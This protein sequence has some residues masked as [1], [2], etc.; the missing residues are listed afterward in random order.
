MSS[1][2]IINRVDEINIEGWW[3]ISLLQ[4]QDDLGRIICKVIEIK[5]YQPEIEGDKKYLFQLISK[6]YISKLK[7]RDAICITNKNIIKNWEVINYEEGNFYPE[8]EN[9]TGEISLDNRFINLVSSKLINDGKC[10]E[11]K[12]NS[13]PENKNNP[14]IKSGIDYGGFCLIERLDMINQPIEYLIVL[15]NNKSKIIK[16]INKKFARIKNNKNFNIKIL[17]DNELI[18]NNIIIK[19][20]LLYDTL[21]V[22]LPKQKFWTTHKEWISDYLNEQMNEL[23][24]VFRSFNAKSIKYTITKNTEIN[25]NFTGEIGCFGKGFKGK[26]ESDKLHNTKLEYN[27]KYDKPLQD[28]YLNKNIFDALYLTKENTR[29]T[30]F[31]KRN[32]DFFYFWKHPEWIQQLSHKT[33]GNCSEMDFSH[34]ETINNNIDKNI[35][36]TLNKLNISYDKNVSTHL[37]YEI[38]LNIQYY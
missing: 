4:D 33:I 9:V 19:N 36:S 12:H 30:V 15:K 5:D 10:R 25:N 11:L 7:F 32:L 2:D 18:K 3:N 35:A 24:K 14:Y 29:L 34:E 27:I 22:K 37:R 13:N 20:I 28:K 21:Y 31:P 17:F 23:I 1:L 6:K 26:K 16:Q 8:L 38:L